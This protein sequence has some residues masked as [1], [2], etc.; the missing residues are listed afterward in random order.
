MGQTR[1]MNRLLTIWFVLGLAASLKA[2]PIT[3]SKD[4]KYTSIQAA[5]EAVEPGGIVRVRAGTY[6]GNVMID[7]AVTLVGDGWDQTRVEMIGKLGATIEATWEQAIQMLE[8]LPLAERRAKARKLFERSTNRPLFIRGT[9]EVTIRGMGFF[10][11][12]PKNVNPPAVMQLAEITNAVVTLEDVAVVGSPADGILVHGTGRI[13]MNRCLVAGNWGRGLVVGGRGRSVRS[14]RIRDCD[15]RHNYQS[16]ITIYTDPEGTVIEGCRLYGS[17]FFGLRPGGSRTLIAGNVIFDNARTAFYSLGTSLVISNNLLLNNS[18][19]GIVAWDGNRDLVVNNTFVNTNSY[20]ISTIGTAKPRVRNN[21]F[22]GHRH[23]LQSSFSAALPRDKALSGDMDLGRNLF[24][25]NETNWVHAI[26]DPENPKRGRLAV[27]EI[28]KAK[29]IGLAPGFVDVARRDYRLRADSLARREGVGAVSF[30]ALNSPFPIQP[31]ELAIIPEP[32]SWSFSEWKKPPKPDLKELQ[33]RLMALLSNRPAAPKRP[34]V[35]YEDAFADLY[36][37]LAKRYPNFELKNI[38]WKA[39]WKELVP[40]IKHV[41]NDRDFAYL[42]YELVARLEDSHAFVGKGLISPPAVDYPRWD[43]GFACLLDDRGKPVVYHLVPGGS[44]EKSGLRIGMTI[45]SLNGVPAIDVIPVI[46]KGIRR[47]SGFSSERYLRY[48]AVRW[49]GRKKD[50]NA[51]V[52]VTVEVAAGTPTTIELNASTPVRYL[53]RLPVANP[54]IRDSGN[55]S[56]KMLSGEIGLIFVRRIRNDLIAQLDQA[57]G[58]LKDAKG[59]IIDVRGNSGGGFD[60]NRAHRNFVSD[61]SLE[62][63]RP[64][65]TGPMALL[66]D[67]RCVSAGEGWASWFIAKQRAKVFGSATAGASARKTTYP[68]KNGLFKVTFPVKPYRGY[69]DRIIE[70]R[71]LEPDVRIRQSAKDL[72]QGRDTVL[73]AARGYLMER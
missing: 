66:I 71:G 7:K 22:T 24:W 11:A 53:P 29:L 40:R 21:I 33:E 44:A 12:G 27:E 34:K 3:V 45:D 47:Y 2:A 36:L 46:M 14:A 50:E 28:G 70:R 15:I 61:R 31:E 65:F 62:P 37:T 56:W 48:T 72:Q 59:L 69:L 55:V 49:L 5:I 64:R 57:V 32:G 6:Q 68:L 8:K 19:G 1:D 25:R 39:V 20:G 54:G 18:F 52:K 16:H 26:P 4:G 9:N 43:A 41:K 67:S 17:A 38:D 13:S 58:E 73:E 42:C 30:P 10:W 60:F 23:A 35:S 63:D 51:P